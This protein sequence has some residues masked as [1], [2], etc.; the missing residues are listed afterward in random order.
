MKRKKICYIADWFND[1]ERSLL[2]E[3]PDFDVTCILSSKYP[4]FK[5][6][7]YRIMIFPVI[8]IVKFFRPN[9]PHPFLL[10][11]KKD[12]FRFLDKEKPD[13]I[14]C[15][16]WHKISTIQMA[17]YCKK[18][19]IP[20]ILQEEMQ[21][22]PKNNLERVISKL[23]YNFFGKSIIK[24]SKKILPWTN[25][26]KIFWESKSEAR[27]KLK[28]L[29]P[30]VDI[31]VFKKI[32]IKRKA[33]ELKILSVARFVDYKRHIDLLQAIKSLNNENVK[34]KLTLVGKGPLKKTIKNVV[35]KLKIEHITEFI[36]YIPH[37]EMNKIYCSHDL[38]VLP[39]Y[40]EAIGMV[41]PESMACG[42][43][44]IVSDTSGAQTYITNHING[45]IFKTFDHKDLKNKIKICLNKKVLKNMGINAQKHIK[46]QFTN[47]L[48]QLKFTKIL[49][50]LLNEQNN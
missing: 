9:K 23:I 25:S 49:R 46:R 10:Y 6:G 3:L 1:I 34:I 24:Q 50:D 28:V 37:T 35:K 38:L 4:E 44:A 15:N 19:K 11:Y 40:N 7:T 13:L 41:V 33:N 26:S 21:R 5:K 8:D 22:W 30:G 42:L 47:D 43:P 17:R 12:I 14:I 27:N 20:F 36:E 45:L 32:K 16:L 48:V 39:S 2:N 29:S 18:K 31:S